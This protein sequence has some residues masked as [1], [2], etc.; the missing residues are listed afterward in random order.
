MTGYKYVHYDT[1]V[2]GWRTTFWLTCPECGI[3]D[4]QEPAA[5]KPTVGKRPIR[6]KCLNCGKVF[7]WT[8]GV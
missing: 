4:F 8:E 3:P 7:L 5:K 1:T 2:H 6:V